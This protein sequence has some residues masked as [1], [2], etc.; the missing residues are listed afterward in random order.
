MSIISGDTI[1]LVQAGITDPYNF[2]QMGIRMVE[3][4]LWEAKKHFKNPTE[5]TKQKLALISGT[6]M[7]ILFETFG[8]GYNPLRL[9]EAFFDYFNA[10]T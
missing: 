7:K 8:I 6:G 9:N 4:E 2:A 5:K 1:N 3:Y 10:N